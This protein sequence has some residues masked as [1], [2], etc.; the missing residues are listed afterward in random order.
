[1]RTNT[2]RGL[3]SAVWPLLSFGSGAI[4]DLIKQLNSGTGREGKALRELVRDF[5][6][7]D[8]IC[9]ARGFPHVSYAYRVFPHPEPVLDLGFLGPFVKRMAKIQA[10][11]KSYRVTPWPA[12]PQKDGWKFHW[13]RPWTTLSKSSVPRWVSL[14]VIH[15]LA[16]I[17]QLRRVRQCDYCHRWFFADRN[18]QRFCS[19]I[20]RE[21][22]WRTSAAGRTKRAAYM[23]RYRRGLDRRNRNALKV[24]KNLKRDGHRSY[25]K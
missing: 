15:D 4:K 7:M 11:Y 25:R 13:I 22:D 3:R 19:P 21:K 18:D 20:C 9:R 24:A 16:V 5:N 14:S 2:K 12:Y 10:A 6:Q 1:M 17:G 8:D 23:Q